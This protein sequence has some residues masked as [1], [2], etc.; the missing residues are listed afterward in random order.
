MRISDWMRSTAAAVGAAMI[1]ASGA[2]PTLAASAEESIV[3]ISA[4]DGQ[5]FTL[6][7]GP[8]AA[9]A[10]DNYSVTFGSGESG[11]DGVVA[12]VQLM[13]LPYPELAPAAMQAVLAAFK[14]KN[15]GMKL[16]PSRAY[17]DGGLDLIQADATVLM[18]GHVFVTKGTVVFVVSAG[19]LAQADLVRPTAD[20]LAAA[21]DTIL[22]SNS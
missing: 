22:A 16:S 18:E 4:L 14:T 15:P 1:V 11:T 10:M 3:P 12:I 7:E 13:V 21:Q 5:W 9:W 8:N 17:G 2:A 20:T 19:D 6:S